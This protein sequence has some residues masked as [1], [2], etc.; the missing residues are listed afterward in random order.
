MNI[1]SCTDFFTI[2]YQYLCVFCRCVHRVPAG[3]I[4][5]RSTLGLVRWD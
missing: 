3:S 5:R 1:I 4:F 2:F